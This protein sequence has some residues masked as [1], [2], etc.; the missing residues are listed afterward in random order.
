MAGEGESLRFLTEELFGILIAFRPV[1]HPGSD[2]VSVPD[3]FLIARSFY[4]K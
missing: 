2:T 4:K 1:G 3:F